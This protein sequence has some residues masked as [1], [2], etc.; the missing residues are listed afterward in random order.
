MKVG[1]L[2][3]IVDTDSVGVVSK[4]L[5]HPHGPSYIDDLTGTMV[6]HLLFKILL[7]NGSS[8]YKAESQLG[9]IE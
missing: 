9:K 8:I 7:H 2:V 3:K 6:P 5:D 1:D 4:K